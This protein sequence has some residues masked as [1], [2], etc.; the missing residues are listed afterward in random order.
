MSDSD[1]SPP[2]L[3]SATDSDASGDECL[4]GPFG[5]PSLQLRRSRW[6]RLCAKE[7][8]KQKGFEGAARRRKTR[9][10]EGRSRA[11]RYEYTFQEGDLRRW[12]LDPSNSPWWDDLNHP[13]VGDERS[14][15][16]RRFRQKFR[17]PYAMVM[18][19]LHVLLRLLHVLLSLLLHAML[20][21][22]LLHVFF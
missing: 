10:V 7:K 20:L 17:L 3:V 12:L 21:L 22:L 4:F 5:G 1:E 13:E 11:G 15:A 18:K 9:A 8:Q 6:E 14:R 19:L 16:G 2:D